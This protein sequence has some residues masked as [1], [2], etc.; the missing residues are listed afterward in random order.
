MTQEK[1]SNLTVLNS[2]KERT[3]KFLPPP[4]SKEVITGLRTLKTGP[5][6][7]RI[8]T[9]HLR[10]HATI[11]CHYTTEAANVK[12]FNLMPGMELPPANTV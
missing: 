1:F 9:R 11:P 12:V 6:A 7:L 10:H 3:A 2:H 5:R 4:N 8:R